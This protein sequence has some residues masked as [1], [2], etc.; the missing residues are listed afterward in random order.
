MTSKLFQPNFIK[1]SQCYWSFF[2][3]CTIALFW[4]GLIRSQVPAFRDASHFYYPQAVWLEQCAA[5]GEYFPLWQTNEGFG[6]SVPGETTSALFYPLRVIWFVPFA[7]VAQRFSLAILVHLW[8]AA[9]GMS[10]ACHRLPLRREAGWL[11]GTA[12][13]LSCPV[14]FQHN[15]FVYLCSAAWLGFGL[16][17]FLCLL[18]WHTSQKRRPRMAV[19]AFALALMVLGG[20]PHTPVNLVILFSTVLIGQWILHRNLS[21]FML[22]LRWLAAGVLLALGLSAV[23]SVPSGL[24]ATQSHRWQSHLV[25]T[26]SPGNQLD[27]AVFV[28]GHTSVPESM[29]RLLNQTP[30]PP[31][32]VYEF[33]LSPWHLLTVVW[34]TLGGSFSPVHAR[35]FSLFPAE[36]R[37]W[38]PSLFFGIIPLL[39]AVQQFLNVRESPHR[40]LVFS[41]LFAI[42][43][44]LGNYSLGWLMRQS[45][46][47]ALPF[48]QDHLTSLYGL[49]VE[50]IPG[51]GVF[52]YPAK[53]TVIGIACL[54]ILAAIRLNEVD[55]TS[56]LRLS[57][58][59]GVAIIASLMGLVFVLCLFLFYQPPPVRGD[60]WLGAPNF[61]A[62]QVAMAFAFC[63]PPVVWFAMHALYQRVERLKRQSPPLRLPVATV[64]A[65]LAMLE[66][67]L[68][69]TQWCSFIP[70]PSTVSGTSRLVWC[71]QSQANILADRWPHHTPQAVFDY[72][73][74][75]LVGKLGLLN[76]K[77]NLSASASIE[78][79]WY[80]RLRIGL[81]RIDHQD[82]VQPD[83]DAVLAWL[84]VQER[85]VRSPEIDPTKPREFHW[86]AIDH[87]KPM[88]ELVQ[89]SDSAAS[90]FGQVEWHWTNSSSLSIDVQA[91]VAC[92]LIVRQF[93]DGGWYLNRSDGTVAVV[94][95]LDS[96]IPFLAIDVAPGR[97]QYQVV[98]KR[99]P[100]A[101]GAT[102]SF[103]LVLVVF[104]ANRA[105]Y[106]QAKWRYR[107]QD[108]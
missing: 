53:W 79:D 18:N 101:I 31:A 2:G 12:Y 96:R 85:L 21:R 82:K 83:L 20:D 11:A 61:N 81:A 72:Q 100:V 68:V 32:S 29:T 33:S 62:M 22:C 5:R 8:I 90:Q 86:Q 51:Y 26:S 97:R 87:P 42:A 66:L 88:C 104:W 7:S 99:W 16:A 4:P 56:L 63:V 19:M 9:L 45:N 39:M 75:F 37:M 25:A 98:R 41:A 23:Q 78:P 46:A 49:M 60:P 89:K 102:V 44:S 105:R 73:R 48:T 6:A 64:V 28:S 76:A 65:W 91:E 3:L 55:A 1:S 103:M 30:P 58:K 27:Q 94:E 93:N 92:L 59:R 69:A 40:W 34:P 17:E 50:V 71:D 80:R 43:A 14:M 13:A 15:N 38:I 24:W 74:Q 106:V 52:R 107:M 35:L 10:Y 67:F 84:G 70:Q 77:S 54:S 108:A 47:I 36:G 95:A 57:R